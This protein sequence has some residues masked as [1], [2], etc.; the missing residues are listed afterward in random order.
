[1]HEARCLRSAS[2]ARA[3]YTDLARSNLSTTIQVM[4]NLVLAARRA[5]PRFDAFV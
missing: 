1:M 2:A 5:H 3:I 4:V